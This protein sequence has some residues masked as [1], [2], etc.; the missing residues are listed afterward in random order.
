[1]FLWE[2]SQF[3]LTAQIRYKLPT[4]LLRLMSILAAVSVE[5]RSNSEL[6][7]VFDVCVFAPI[8]CQI[9]KSRH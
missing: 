5:N 8:I 3:C 4:E 9:R 1:M 7:V 6:F 2:L